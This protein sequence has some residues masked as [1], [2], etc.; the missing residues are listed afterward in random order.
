MLTYQPFKPLHYSD[1]VYRPLT[2]YQ[3]CKG[4]LNAWGV[5]PTQADCSAMSAQTYAI[6]ATVS[7]APFTT[8][9]GK[10]GDDGRPVPHTCFT[11]FVTFDGLLINIHNWA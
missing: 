11:S 9:P 2:A 1:L 6:M 7:D 8:E 3:I 4:P 5:S 10:P